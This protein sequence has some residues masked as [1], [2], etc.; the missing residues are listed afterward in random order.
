[1][2]RGAA[3]T[4]CRGRACPMGEQRGKPKH[5]QKR[6]WKRKRRQKTRRFRRGKYDRHDCNGI[7][8]GRGKRQFFE[9]DGEFKHRRPER[10][11]YSYG[12]TD[13]KRRDESHCGP[14][15]AGT[16]RERGG[17]LLR[18]Q[19]L[20][21]ESRPAEIIVLEIADYGCKNAC[22][23]RQ[24]LQPERSGRCERCARQSAQLVF[25]RQL[26]TCGLHR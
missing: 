21:R 24:C 20:P 8:A 11:K 13:R 26:D 9:Y 4:G 6:R 16:Y 10:C 17:A 1:M 14:P 3:P 5:R 2:G 7:D 23:G 12:G 18:Y 19:C 15:G 22:G 25:A